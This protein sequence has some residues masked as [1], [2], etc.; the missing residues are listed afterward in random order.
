M[1]LHI[2]PEELKTY[3]YTKIYIQMMTVKFIHNWKQARYPSVGEWINKSWNIKTMKFYLLLKRKELTSHKK[4]Q[5]ELQCILLSKRSQSKKAPNC[6]T[7]LYDNLERP[8]L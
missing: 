3:V 5:K 4:T 1:L 2:Y 6:I 7:P 8:K